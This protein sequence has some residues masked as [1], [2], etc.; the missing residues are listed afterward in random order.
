MRSAEVFLRHV[1]TLVGAKRD[2][3]V[4]RKSAITKNKMVRGAEDVCGTFYA[5]WSR[6][7]RGR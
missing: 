6:I 7:K 2:W 4:V 1:G 3:L 5:C